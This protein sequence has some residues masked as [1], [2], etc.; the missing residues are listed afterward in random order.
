[1]SSKPGR[2]GRL[3]RDRP[4]PLPALFAV[5][6]GLV[7]IAMAAPRLVAGLLIAPHDE[8]VRGLSRET[9]GK[10]PALAEAS[11][12]YEAALTWDDEANS[13]AQLATLDY[14]LAQSVGFE[15]EAGL[16][17][18][19]RTLAAAR[20]AV[21]GNP[22]QPYTWV[23]IALALERLEGTSER[24]VAALMESIRRGAFQPRLAVLRSGLALR[25]WPLLE[26]EE[27]R[28]AAGQILLA[29][30]VDPAA[31]AAVVPSPSL[32]RVVQDS[33]LGV[34]DL[35]RAVE[36]GRPPS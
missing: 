26:A 17:W 10:G 30:E 20:R 16:T 28:L 18:L 29:A 9:I 34:P 12:D 21:A 15:S 1:L 7:L 23:Q 4:G 24:S 22:A 36:A 6:L 25:A 31:L 32:W 2:I 3:Y 19:R 33:L 5:L 14:L 13:A 35:L 27:R 8:L 11:A